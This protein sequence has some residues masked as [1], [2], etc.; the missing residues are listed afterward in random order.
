MQGAGRGYDR[1]VPG[2]CPTAPLGT[3]GLGFVLS[4]DRMA[5]LSSW[6]IRGSEFREVPARPVR[7]ATAAACRPA[8]RL[9]PPWQGGRALPVRR[10][11][12]R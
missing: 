12:D 10:P 3:V 2:G 1:A 9:P 7:E 11:G 4:G 8:G 5:P 6:S